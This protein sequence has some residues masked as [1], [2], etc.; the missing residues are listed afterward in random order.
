M[1]RFS[2]ICL[3]LPIFPQTGRQSCCSHLLKACS[4]LPRKELTKNAAARYTFEP[5]MDRL[6]FA[7]LQM[8]SVFSAIA[9]ASSSRPHL[10]FILA[11]DLVSMIF[12]SFYLYVNRRASCVRMR[13]RLICTQCSGAPACKRSPIP[14]KI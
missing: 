9:H 8:L 6:V 7:G 3:G 14:E 12:I 4:Y 13:V 11:D 2:S 10:I 1:T 5:A